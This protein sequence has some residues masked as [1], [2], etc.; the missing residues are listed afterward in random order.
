MPSGSSGLMQDLEYPTV[1]CGGD[2]RVL[3]NFVSLRENAGNFSGKK[4][5]DSVK[6]KRFCPVDRDILFVGNP[7]CRSSW[8][9]PGKL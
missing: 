5:I 7:C 9:G 4:A 8:A 6:L 3:R 2:V 1:T